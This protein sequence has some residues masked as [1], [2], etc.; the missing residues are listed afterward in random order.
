MFVHFIITEGNQYV[1]GMK[2]S[3]SN[4][5]N[6]FYCRL[7]TLKPE[8]FV[9]T[10]NH[11]RQIYDPSTLPKNFDAEQKWPNYISPIEDQGWCG[12]SW[13]ISTAAVASDRW[14]N[15]C[16]ILW[17][18][19]KMIFFATRRYAIVSRGLE[20]VR[21]S[22]QHLLSCDFRGQQSCKGGYL[23]RAWNFVRKYGWVCFKI[24][25]KIRV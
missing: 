10:M 6:F 3:R 8:R 7:G 2:Y 15:F 9:L 4:P 19:V 24:K 16:F 20:R 22:P 25:F 11:V 5:H 21:L 23:D 12:S 1:C 18:V 13:A 14:I 17:N